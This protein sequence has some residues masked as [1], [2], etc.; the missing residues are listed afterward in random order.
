L[1]DQR[2]QRRQII[3]FHPE[4]DYGN[5]QPRDVLFGTNAAIGCHEGFEAFS[6]CLSEQCAILQ[7]LPPKVR[8]R[9]NVVPDDFVPETNVNAFI[10]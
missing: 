7:T 5:R 6:R 3:R 4:N 8:D 1:R 9:E 10:E 2:L